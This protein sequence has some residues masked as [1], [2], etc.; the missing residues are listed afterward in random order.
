[1]K[2]LIIEDEA[3]AFR[4][5]QRILEEIRENIDII[6]VIDS[7][8]ESVKWLRNHQLP[9]LIFMDIQLADGLSF[10]IFNQVKVTTPVIFTTAYDEYTLKAFKV[11]SID[12]LLKPINKELL[13]ESLNKYDTLKETFSAAQASNLVEI[14]NQIK[15]EEKRYKSRFLIKIRDQLI[16]VE[17]NNIAYFYTEH[18]L[19]YAKTKQDKK[20]LL[21][22]T[23]DELKACLDPKSF[24]RINRQYIASFQAISTSYQW[25][26]GKLKVVLSPKTTNEVLI[27]RDRSTDFK[28]WLDF[29]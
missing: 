3:P 16:A 26:K 15:P 6:D 22:F 1:V 25:E 7:I 21:D 12:Y 9:D 27:S 24:F 28:R 8:E 20:Y 23:L 29:Y 2:V 17:T 4:R 10:D 19:V 18:A 11:N 14:L 5:L 13:R